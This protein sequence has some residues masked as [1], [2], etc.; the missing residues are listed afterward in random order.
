MKKR[1]DRIITDI[2]GAE[3]KMIFSTPVAWVMLVVLAVLCARAFLSVFGLYAEA[4]ATEPHISFITEGLFCS[5]SYGLFPTVQSYLFLFIPLVSMGIVSRDLDSST[6]G[7]LYSSPVSNSQI[8][9]GKYLALLG[10]G[11]ALMLIVAL[12]AVFGCFAV[13]NVDI[14]LLLTGMLGLFLLVCAYA[15]IGVFMSSL[16][17]YQVVSAIA[18]FA[19]LAGLSALRDFG[20]DIPWV[21]DVTWWL[22]INGRCGQFIK[23][24]ISSEDI[25]Y[26][27]TIVCGFLSLSVI[28]LDALRRNRTRFLAF[29]RCLGVMAAVAVVAFVSTRPAL[30]FYHDSTETKRRTI[31][32]PSQEVMRR[33]KGPVTITTYVN[34]LD[35]EGFYLGIPSRY[36]FD[37]DYLKPYL[38]FKPEIRQK[39]VYYWADAGSAAVRRRFPDLSDEQRAERITDVYEMNFD[40]FLTPQQIA[41]KVDLSGEGYRLVKHIRLADGRSTF[42]RVFDD[43]ERQPGEKEITAAFKRLLD[44]S[45]PVGFVTGHGERNIFGEGDADYKA[46][47][48]SRHFRH[49]L[50]NNGFDA[51]TLTPGEAIPDSIKILVIA[52]PRSGFAA[53]EIAEIEKYISR[54]GDLILS[55]EPGRQQYANEIAGLVGVEFQNGRVASPKGEN[56]Q[57]LVLATVSAESF[58]EIPELKHVKGHGYKVTMPNAVQIKP[59]G[60]EGYTYKK[61][62][63]SDA[64]SWNELNTTDFENEE[65]VCDAAAGESVGHKVVGALMHRTLD[66]GREQKIILLGDTD[67]FSNIELTRDRYAVASGNFSLL[68]NVFHYLS[69]GQYPVDTP[70]AGCTDT[71]L[72][73]GMPQMALVKCLFYG[74]VPIVLLL[75]ASLVIMRRKSR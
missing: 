8:M 45:V 58:A 51:V 65:A 5:D 56:P 61:L 44:G 30:R 25:I 63:Y 20:Q 28:R 7:L 3:L 13:D 72:R 59:V 53:G 35:E 10:Y 47:A 31:T 73:I 41:S 74:L 21:R 23:G 37:M 54:G 24:L 12:F 27:I 62:L 19:V 43:S 2:A 18:T 11:C 55:T 67:C 49:S 9:V 68:Y 14:P 46:F 1:T 36:N 50:L 64:G 57:N 66:G 16:T 75:T 60:A 40:K 32:V 52:D 4:A 38:W 70:R 71:T 26:F 6:I 15:A 69:D 34:A 42:L 39:Y 33:V 17:S 22:S 48:T 29:V